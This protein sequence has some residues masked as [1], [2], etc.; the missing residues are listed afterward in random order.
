MQVQLIPSPDSLSPEEAFAMAK[1]AEVAERWEDMTQYMVRAV[2]EKSGDD[3]AEKEIG[4]EMRNL[5]S[6]AFKNRVT[7]RRTALRVTQQ[8]VEQEPMSDETKARATLYLGEIAEELKGLIAEVVNNV[9]GKFVKG[10]EAATDTEVL[11]F[12]HKMEGDYNRYGAEFT[13][14]DE[15]VGFTEQ[16][17]SA[18]EKAHGLCKRQITSSDSENVDELP[19]TN[20][21]RLG[22]ALN[23]SVFMYEILD[24]KARAEEVAKGAF[25]EAIN[26]LD[27]LDENQYRDSTLIM[28]LLK[29][30]LNL[31]HSD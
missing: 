4:I 30:N 9:V 1:H 26:Q 25:E 8:Q 10:P 14:A 12:F 2:R 18:Y 23:Y 3:L 20:P 29:D 15:K 21:I 17:K 31:W 22:L 16:A 27:D 11:V 7:A 24:E 28:Q 6:V 5:L 19:P 13:T